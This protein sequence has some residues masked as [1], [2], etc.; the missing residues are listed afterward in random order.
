MLFSEIYGSYFRVLE[1][2]LT[3]ASAGLLTDRQLTA[4]VQEQA[5]AESGLSIPAK[6]KSGQL[7]GYLKIP[8]DFAQL[9]LAGKEAHLQYV[10]VRNPAQLGSV[11]VQ[12]IGVTVSEMLMAAQ[13]GVYAAGDYAR[14]ARLSAAE[15]QELNN[16]INMEYIELALSRESLYEL[17]ELGY[18]NELPFALYYVCGFIVLLMMLWGL[19]CIRLLV[20]TDLTLSRVLRLRGCSSVAQVLA[21]YLS[22]LLILVLNLLLVFAVI[23]TVVQ[24]TGFSVAFLRYY[25][26]VWQFLWLG[27]SLI[28]AA[29]LIATLQYCL[30]TVTTQIIGAAVIQIVSLIALAF[31][32]GLLLPANTL[33]P[34]LRTVAPYLP[35]GMGLEYVGGVLTDTTRVGAL[36]ILGY[37]VF[38]L[39]IAALAREIAIREVQQ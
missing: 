23:G 34:L 30:Y 9:L 27:V 22:F 18:S 6:L 14:Q 24:L 32:G 26:T 38:F 39:G 21:E 35:T 2:I 17:H 16:R 11:M 5:F 33:P 7:M 29:A 37:C 20:K 25:E 8:A 19:V 28:P 15:R 13:N 4:L 1:N 10:T 36:P 31:A 12:E 3:Q